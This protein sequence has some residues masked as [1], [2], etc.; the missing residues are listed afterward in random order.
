MAKDVYATFIKIAVEQGGLSE[1]FA[2][3]YIKTLKSNGRY[4]EDTWS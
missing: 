1:S 2:T 4:L 3:Q